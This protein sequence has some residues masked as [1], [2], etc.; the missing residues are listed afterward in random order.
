MAAES[1][2]VQL[3]Q[4]PYASIGV[5]SVSLQV[6]ALFFRPPLI[7]RSFQQLPRV[8]GEGTFKGKQIKCAECFD[9]RGVGEFAG[10]RAPTIW[11]SRPCE[12]KDE[13]RAVSI[14]MR[15]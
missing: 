12:T 3:C 10:R 7:S 9:W 13:P 2:S 14:I 15:S 11:F 1:E 6:V 4:A 5:E 8:K